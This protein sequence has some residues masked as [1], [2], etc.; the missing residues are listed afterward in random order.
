MGPITGSLKSPRGDSKTNKPT[1]G[2]SQSVKA[3]SHVSSGA[4]INWKKA[5][6]AIADKPRDA[7]L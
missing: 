4:S 3:L 1:D 6:A 7:V 2:Q 5:H